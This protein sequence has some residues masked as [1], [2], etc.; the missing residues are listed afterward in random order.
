M[1]IDSHAHLEMHDFD[2][3]RRDAVTRA[4]QAGVHR[5]I[6][7]GTTLADCRKAAQLAQEFDAVYAAIGIHPHD[8]KGIDEE[9]YRQLKAL[10]K[11]DKVVA[12]GEIGLDFFHRHSPRETQIQ[13]FQEQLQIARDVDLPIIIHD[14]EA[15]EQTLAL[16]KEWKGGRGGVI[17]CFSGDVAMADI[18]L[19]MGFYISIAGPVTYPKSDMLKEVVRHV[20]LERLLI[21]TDSPYLAPQANRGKRNEPAY[22]VHTARQIAAIKDID[23]EDV[24][25]VTALNAQ[26]LFQLPPAP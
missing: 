13:R 12:W 2:H 26:Q 8:A 11:N 9:T 14:R 3:D 1:F 21:E 17:H 18:C 7:V 19:E 10:A 20:P 4:A 16:L 24:G 15:H 6:T 25:R 5:I 23:L 22:V